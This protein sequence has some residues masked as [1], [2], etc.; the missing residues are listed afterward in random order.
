VLSNLINNAVQ[1]VD[2]Q[3]EV[4][5]TTSTDSK[6]L[7]IKISDS[8][9]GIPEKNMSK[10]FEPM[11]TTKTTGTGLGLVICKSIVEQHGGTISISNKPTTFTVTLPL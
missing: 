2:G 3:G 4:N 7:T 8:G 9:P 11:F 5:V 10:I 1:A 6:F